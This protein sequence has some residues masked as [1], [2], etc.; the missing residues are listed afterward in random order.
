[1][2]LGKLSGI[3]TRKSLKTAREDDCSA[4]KESIKLEN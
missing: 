2:S 3:G 1:M 4:I